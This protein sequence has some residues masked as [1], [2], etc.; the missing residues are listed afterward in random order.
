MKRLTPCLVVGL[1]NAGVVMLGN[2][3]KS[4]AQSSFAEAIDSME[5]CCS[6]TANSNRGGKIGGVYQPL[7]FNIH[8]K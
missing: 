4:L 7:T 2:S 6:D 3:A 5:C 1:S 8:K